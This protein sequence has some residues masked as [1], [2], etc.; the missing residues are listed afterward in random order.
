MG[1]NYDVESRIAQNLATSFCNLEAKKDI[2]SIFFDIK[3]GK[4][5]N[6]FDNIFFQ[7]LEE[8]IYDSFFL[9]GQYVD[10]EKAINVFRKTVRKTIKKEIHSYAMTRFIIIRG[11]YYYRNNYR[12]V[13]EE[14][15]FHEKWYEDCL[16]F[17]ED[18]A[19]EVSGDLSWDKV[20]EF[21][22][23]LNEDLK[24]KIN[25]RLFE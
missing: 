20:E 24:T 3:E 7:T 15:F 14:L 25:E 4:L 23:N 1:R 18:V 17:A 11:M 6:I 2:N 19:T 5:N 12:Y 16:K 9:I 21:W 8:D 22:D 13:F 10:H